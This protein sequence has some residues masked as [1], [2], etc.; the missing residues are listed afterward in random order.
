MDEIILAVW[1]EELPNR[2][3]YKIGVVEN[4]KDEEE[5][6][7]K[8]KNAMI[9]K[10]W[11]GLQL[12]A[13]PEYAKMMDELCWCCGNIRLALKKP[14]GEW[15]DALCMEWEGIIDEIIKHRCKYIDDE[16]YCRANEKKDGNCKGTT[17]SCSKNKKKEN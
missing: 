12:F 15:D 16:F 8:D 9:V 7:S 11:S 2:R 1:F 14:N 5:M 3:N 4:K 6:C 10:H 13:N 17:T